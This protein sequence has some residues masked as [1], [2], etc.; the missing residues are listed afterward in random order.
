MYYKSKKKILCNEKAEVVFH[1][2][3]IPFSLS[4]MKHGVIEKC[5]AWMDPNQLFS[6]R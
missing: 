2:R 4:E 1:V 6:G 5:E 3:I